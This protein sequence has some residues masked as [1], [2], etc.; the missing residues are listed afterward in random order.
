MSVPFPACSL[1]VYDI[2]KKSGFP[3]PSGLL[4]SR[5]VRINLSCWVVPN[6][7]EPSALLDRMTKAGVKWKFV[8]FDPSDGENL[9]ETCILALTAD[10]KLA[11]ARA[12]KSVKTAQDKAG[13]GVD[14]RKECRLYTKRAGGTVSRMKKMLAAFRK[15]TDTFGIDADRHL[16]LSDA[17]NAVS[18][19]SEAVKARSA[20]YAQAVEDCRALADVDAVAMA[21][22]AA[23]DACPWWALAE[24]LEDRGEDVGAL[25][26]AFT[27][28]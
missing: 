19:L 7:N 21:T 22:A 27:A 18:G 24:F 26:I 11:V 5:A 12:A 3:N 20:L 13:V 28:V 4:R 17:E 9:M 1:F 15:V 25:K 23:Q 14:A 2:P 8:K 6:G 10:I 16:N